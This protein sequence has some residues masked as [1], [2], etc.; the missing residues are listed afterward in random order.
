MEAFPHPERKL[1][2]HPVLAGCQIR[3]APREKNK[4]GRPIK[5][6]ARTVGPVARRKPKAFCTGNLRSCA[7]RKTNALKTRLRLTRRPPPGNFAWLNGEA[8]RRSLDGTVEV[9]LQVF[10][11]LFLLFKQES[12][13]HSNGN[14]RCK[15]GKNG[16]PYR[17]LSGIFQFGHP[18]F[19]QL[20][21]LLS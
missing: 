9:M 14:D 15:R 18:R 4:T 11:V 17:Q 19:Q 2:V 5:E 3:L 8:R 12:Y 21:L 20:R 13:R 1:A 7:R 6:P 10:F 16:D